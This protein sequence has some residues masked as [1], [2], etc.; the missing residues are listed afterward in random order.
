MGLDPQVAGL[1]AQLSADPTAP[2]LA[3]VPPEVGRAMFRGL[4][5]MLDVQNVPIGKIENRTFPG[6]ACDVPVRIYTPVA[7]GATQTVQVS[8]NQLACGTAYTI[9][10]RSGGGAGGRAAAGGSATNASAR[11]AT[12]SSSHSGEYFRTSIAIP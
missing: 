9:D 6:P 3:D 8:S 12:H 1:L 4:G 7:A 11:S 2:G 5:A 10:A